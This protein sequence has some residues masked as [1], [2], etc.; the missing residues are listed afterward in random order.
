MIQHSGSLKVLRTG[1]LIVFLSLNLLLLKLPAYNC[2]AFQSGSPKSLKT[3]SNLCGIKHVPKPDLAA[4]LPVSQRGIR[5]HK[6]P[7]RKNEMRLCNLR[8]LILA[9]LA[10]LLSARAGIAP[11]HI[12]G[13]RLLAEREHQVWS[14]AVHDSEF[15]ALARASGRSQ[16]GVVQPPQALATPDPLLDEIDLT[17]KVSVS[18]IVGTDGRVHSALILESAGANEDRT[19]LEA[20]RIWRYRPAMCNGVPTEAEARVEFSSR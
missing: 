17:S 9:I 14:T 20:I 4:G 1:K 2:K 16:C 18:F 7:T 15:A 6:A 8:I 13:W 11:V 3:A 10:P 12:G 5:F 19:I